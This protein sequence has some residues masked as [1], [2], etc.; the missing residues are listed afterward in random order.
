MN[1]KDPPKRQNYW[2]I[3]KAIFE[4]SNF[5][6]ESNRI[7]NSRPKFFFYE[8]KKTPTCW[9]NGI[10][11]TKVREVSQECVMHTRG[12]EKCV[13][14]ERNASRPKHRKHVARIFDK[15]RPAPVLFLFR[16]HIRNRL[17]G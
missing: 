11:S 2:D 10:E 14:C 4:N 7:F 9:Y 8:W 13:T 16:K 15:P 17:N 5:P 3:I 1:P 12:N 6:S